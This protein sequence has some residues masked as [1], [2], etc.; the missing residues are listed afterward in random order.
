VYILVVLTTLSFFFFSQNVVDACRWFVV[1]VC[2]GIDLWIDVESRYG[3][4][5]LYFLEMN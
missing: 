2:V 1:V 5:L 4:P 3:I